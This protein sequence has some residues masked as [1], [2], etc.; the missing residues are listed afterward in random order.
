MNGTEENINKITEAISRGQITQFQV[1]L[2]KI[3]SNENSKYVGIEVEFP[4]AV[5]EDKKNKKKN[6]KKKMSDDP[7]QKIRSSI[8]NIFP[9]FSK[10]IHHPHLTLGQVQQEVKGELIQK[11]SGAFIPLEFKVKELVF[12]HRKSIES[13]WRVSKVIPLLQN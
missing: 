10:D 8:Q 11:L 4:N 7:I 12:M 2:E 5:L 13:E 6:Q 9:E 3:F 1:R